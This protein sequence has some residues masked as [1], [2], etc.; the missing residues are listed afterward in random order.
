M[1]KEGIRVMGTAEV[2]P[3]RIVDTA[4]VAA[5]CGIS[6][7]KALQRTGVRTR[8]WLS[9]HEDPL[10]QGVAA[11]E[12]AIR[13]AGL[14]PADV[15]LVINAS[16]TPMQAIPDGGALIAAEL[17]LRGRFAYSVHAT[18]ISFLVALQQAAFHLGSGRADH[19]LIVSTEAGSRGLDFGQP[20]SSIL[21]GDAA[22]AVVVGRPERPDQGIVASRFSTDTHGIRD[23]RIPG[24]G[25]RRHVGDTVGRPEDHVFDMKGLNLL[26]G[27]INWFPPFLESVRPGLSTSAEGIDRIIPHQTSRAGMELMSRFWGWEKMVVTLGEV[28]NTIAASIPLALHRADLKPSETA[29]LVG[30]GA[31]THYGAMIVRW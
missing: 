22:A 18:C 30:T 17:G 21:I 3:E 9:D 5:L 13:A 10:L 8:R 25:S 19:V 6:E 11:A 14:E 2:L 27:A 24:F 23:A 31:G 28:G 16:G 1:L 20:E 29:L 12:Q 15:D 7:E 4:E 26:R